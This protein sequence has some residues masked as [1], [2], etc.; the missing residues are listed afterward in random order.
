MEL[1]GVSLSEPCGRRTCSVVELP[2]AAA[3]ST[4]SLVPGWI[5]AALRANLGSVAR[6]YLVRANRSLARPDSPPVEVWQAS[7]EQGSQSSA[8][9][10]RKDARDAIH[11]FLEKVRAAPG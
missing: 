11:L 3:N 1:P 6:R 8:S 9:R 2:P 10:R 7:V 4:S 5:A